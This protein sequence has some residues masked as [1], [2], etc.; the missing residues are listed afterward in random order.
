MEILSNIINDLLDFSKI[1]SDKFRIEKNPFSLFSTFDNVLNL[2]KNQFE[3]KNISLSSKIDPK[4]PKLINGDKLR[5]NQILMN[6]VGN[7][8]KFTEKGSIKID[9]NII[10]DNEK[11]VSIKISVKDT[12]IG[13]ESQSINKIFERFEQANNKITTKYGGTGLGL[14]ISKRLVE[15]HGGEIGVNSEFDKGSEF[16]FIIPFQKVFEKYEKDEEIALSLT[17]PKRI[18][19]CDDN[20]VNRNLITIMLDNPKIEIS[21]AQNG[22]VVIELLSKKAFDLILMDLHMPIMDGLEA[23]NIIRKE[24]NIKIPIIGISANSLELEKNKLIPIGMNDYVVKP[25]K[26][27]MLFQKINK[28]LNEKNEIQ[29]SSERSDKVFPIA[30]CENKKFVPQT[31]IR[32]KT[33]FQNNKEENLCNISNFDFSPSLNTR[34]KKLQRFKKIFKNTSS[35]FIKY[36]SSENIDLNYIKEVADEDSEAEKHLIEVFLQYVPSEMENLL[37]SIRTQNFI[38]IKSFAH[39][40]KSSIVAFGMYKK[41]NFL[42]KIEK[43]SEKRNIRKI[44]KIFLN[45]QISI[46]RNYEELRESL[47]DLA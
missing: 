35:S 16:F 41:V 2:L 6:L 20:E 17:R 11:E 24:L 36:D 12:G 45:I 42:I 27:K 43:L 1:D 47:L 19:V 15:M 39:K 10:K 21:T 8:L 3:E 46:K 31:K 37:Q 7:A 33:K 44:A 30:S 40:L 23:A 5:I 28:L 4:I 22:K 32:I 26:K 38:M 25:F 13:I 14:S 29:E 34:C 9:A 18:L